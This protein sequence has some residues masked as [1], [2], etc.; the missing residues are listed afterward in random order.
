[1]GVYRWVGVRVD[2]L[3][4][5]NLVDLDLELFDEDGN[6]LM[7]SDFDNWC[8][9]NCPF[10]IGAGSE[11]VFL[12][13]EVVDNEVFFVSVAVAPGSSVPVGSTNSTNGISYRVEVHYS[14]ACGLGTQDRISEYV[15]SFFPSESDGGIAALPHFQTLSENDRGIQREGLH[16]CA[17]ERSDTVFVNLD[18]TRHT[19]FWAYLEFTAVNGS[20]IDLDIYTFYAE[21]PV[22]NPPDN[23]EHVEEWS[24]INVS[25]FFSSNLFSTFCFS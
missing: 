11:W 1:M 7:T 13:R 4:P 3:Y 6:S 22:N 17:G 16:I 5:G 23:G 21:D 15:A 24:S 2:A 25:F 9:P 18:P 20:G 8:S 19:G 14:G 12:D 10:H